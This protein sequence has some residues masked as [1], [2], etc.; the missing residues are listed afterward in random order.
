MKKLLL[1]LFSV[2]LMATM[3]VSCG[4]DALQKE[5]DAIQKDLPMDMGDGMTMTAV[6]L[7]GDYLV[8]TAEIDE[9]IMGEE[10][11]DFFIENSDMLKASMLEE[12]DDPDIQ[13]LAKMCKE[14]NK[15]IAYKFVGSKSGKNLTVKI[16]SNEL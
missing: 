16:E 10:M 7:E 4:T 3:L 12:D 9:D 11:M 1:S 14:R 6:V 2:A 8:Y 15:G 13:E 5:V